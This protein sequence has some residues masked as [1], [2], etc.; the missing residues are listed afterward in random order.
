LARPSRA[1]I[2]YDGVIS[3]MLE[4]LGA[5]ADVSNLH[6]HAVMRGETFEAFRKTRNA[7]DALQSVAGADAK[8][9]AWGRRQ[10]GAGS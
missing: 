10:P 6:I 2:P 9:L 8:P 7:P 1:R 4:E 3:F 5:D